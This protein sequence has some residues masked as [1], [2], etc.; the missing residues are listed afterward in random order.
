MAENLKYGRPTSE[1]FESATILFSEVIFIF[2]IFVFVFVFVFVFS[3]VF[4]FEFVFVS[5]FVSEIDLC[6][7]LFSEID[8]F[9]DL[10]RTCS[11]LE[12]FEMLDLIYKTFDARIDK[13][14][15][16]K[17]RRPFYQTLIKG[18][19]PF[20]QVETINDSYMVASGLPV[21]NGDTHPSEV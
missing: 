10:A 20:P 6:L 9:N 21:Q 14:N 8:G 4:V 11:P 15:V 17:A 19:E 1:M 18:D 7:I 2:Y 12:L 3:F 5:A 16:Y 13:Y